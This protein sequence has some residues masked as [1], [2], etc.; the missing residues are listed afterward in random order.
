MLAPV[1]LPSRSFGH[2]QF[3]FWLW[4][5]VHAAVCQMSFI[6]FVSVRPFGTSVSSCSLCVSCVSLGVYGVAL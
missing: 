4:A 2:D 1:A 3:P 5:A 6:Y